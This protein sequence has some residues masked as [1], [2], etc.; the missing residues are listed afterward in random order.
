[1]GEQKR[2]EQNQTL[3]NTVDSNLISNMQTKAYLQRPRSHHK[4]TSK[5]GG[6]VISSPPRPQVL[7]MRAINVNMFMERRMQRLIKHLI[8][9][10]CLVEVQEN[11]NN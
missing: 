5:M 10:R 11:K 4:H 9:D 1:M 3:S 8:E 2:A 6:G 7:V